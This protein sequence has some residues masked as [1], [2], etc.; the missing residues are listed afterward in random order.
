MKLHLIEKSRLNRNMQ[1]LC[2]CC[3]LFLF[4]FLFLP[5]CN[6]APIEVN[7]PQQDPKLVI[8]SQIIPG[9]F[10]LVTVTR[11]FSAL[12]GEEQKDDSSTAFLRSV[13]VDHAQVV[14]TH[15]GQSDTLFRVSPGVY[16]STVIL[17]DP[18]THIGLSVYD[19]VKGDR[20]TAE[21]YMKPRVPLIE[22]YI[23]YKLEG[24]DTIY[25]LNY[26]FIDP[27]EN[28][29]YVASVLRFNSAE[30]FVQNNA[31]VFGTNNNYVFE[32]VFYDKS[33]PAQNAEVE[34][35]ERLRE[36]RKGDSVAVVFSNIS[37]EY[38]G[39]LEARRR[40]QGLIN[41]ITGEPVNYPSNIKGGYGFFNTHNPDIRTLVVP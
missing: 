19:S 5:S 22:S 15:D 40:S 8:S 26:S 24:T 7:L 38:F 31:N 2:C 36:V 6:P 28:N 14:I 29:W 9:D 20:V 25:Y 27:P 30:T 4:L 41:I 10:M 21:S 34:Q 17:I 35:E 3:A 32:K 11:S 33:L 16:L 1:R 37:M 39:F 18:L 23:D 12:K 13:L